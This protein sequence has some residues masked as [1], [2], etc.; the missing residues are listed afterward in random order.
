MLRIGIVA[1]RGRLGGYGY[2]GTD[3]PVATGVPV[4]FCD[5][6]RHI[7]SPAE[8][9]GTGGVFQGLMAY[10]DPKGDKGQ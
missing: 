7:V 5:P 9:G 2:G 10:L 8:P 3:A 1:V 4:Y 6:V